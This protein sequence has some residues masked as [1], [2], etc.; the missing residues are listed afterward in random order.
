MLGKSVYT[1]PTG[2][3]AVRDGNFME[4]ALAEL[5]CASDFNCISVVDDGCDGHSPFHI[6]RQLEHT[7]EQNMLR[8]TTYEE[9]EGM[10]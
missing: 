10:K 8:C 7:P 3:C 1:I 2:A 5:S 6:C 9:I 4:L